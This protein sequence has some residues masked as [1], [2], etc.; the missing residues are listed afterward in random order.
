[1]HIAL[2]WLAASFVACTRSAAH[3][4]QDA[5][6]GPSSTAEASRTVQAPA[7]VISLETGKTLTLQSKHARSATLEPVGLVDLVTGDDAIQLLGRH[8]GNVRLSL[9]DA[10][11]TSRVVDIVVVPA[12][13]AAAA[14]TEPDSPAKHETKSALSGSHRLNQAR[15]AMKL[16]NFARARDLLEPVLRGGGSPEERTTLR[17]VCKQLHDQACVDALD[18]KP[19]SGIADSRYE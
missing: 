1:M 15:E 18:P 4:Q 5:G 12:T 6:A 14:S 11:D 10:D 9:T 16:G 19:K 3:E 2:F 17:A 8:P 7:L 13:S